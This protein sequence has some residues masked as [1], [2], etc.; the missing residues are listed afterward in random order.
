MVAILNKHGHI[1]KHMHIDDP[2]ELLGINTRIELAAADTLLRARNVRQWMLAGVTIEQ[3]E[4]VTIDT[5]VRIG[6]D[7]I[8]GPFAQ[9][10]GTTVIGEDCTVGAGSILTNAKLGDRVT[11]DAFTLIADSHIGDDAGVG[12]FARLRMNNEVGPK[13]K[14]G[15]FVELK[16]TKIGAGVKAQHLAYLGDSEIGEHTNI[17]AGTITC[18]FDG[19]SKHKTK[20]GA[21]A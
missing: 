11:V 6:M 8:I 3:P 15:N 4:T 9:L 17:G 10:R 5:G 20:I 14:I 19:T 16:K 13:A 1:V 2:S 7:S 18:N 12:P 21:A